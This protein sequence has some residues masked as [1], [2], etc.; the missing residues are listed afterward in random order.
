MLYGWTRK[1][2][3]SAIER[4]SREIAEAVAQHE[5]P[6]KIYLL[7]RIMARLEAIRDGERS[8]NGN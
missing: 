3:D 1:Q 7:R 2:L 8:K 4:K 5:K 6:E